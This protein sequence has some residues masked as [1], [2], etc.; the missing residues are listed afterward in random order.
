MDE[1]TARNF[2]TRQATQPQKYFVYFKAL[3]RGIE[4]K[5]LLLSRADIFEAL[6]L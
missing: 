4:A 5:E 3:L 1:M 2:G 6:P